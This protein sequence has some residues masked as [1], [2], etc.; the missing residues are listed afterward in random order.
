M[1]NRNADIFRAIALLL[2]VT[3]HSWVLTG[4]NEIFIYPVRL[5]VALGGE[6]GVTSFFILSGFGIYYSLN[7]TDNISFSSF[8]KK[9]FIR[10]AP[11]YYIFLLIL[12]LF[13][14]DVSFISFDGLDDIILHAL[15][16]H[17][18]SPYTA[19]TIN[20]VLWTMSLTVQFYLLAIP[21]YYVIKKHPYLFSIFSILFTILF[22]F[23]CFHYLMKVY[24]VDQY[25]WYSRNLFPSILDNFVLGMFVANRLIDGKKREKN[26]LIGIIGVIFFVISGYL[27]S[28]YS[29]TNG[30]HQDN[31]SGYIY[32][33]LIAICISGVLY[34][35]SDIKINYEAFIIK[36]LLKISD[37]EYGI[38]IVHLFLMQNLLNG[39]ALFINIKNF[40]VLLCMLML[41]VLS[42]IIGTLYSKAVSLIKRYYI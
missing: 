30:I 9:R 18:L 13:S 11:E 19:G 12:L 40:S 42:I 29:W 2:V 3:Y 31:L 34:F 8:M 36:I 15:F 37:F 32:H 39:S 17:N 27:I 14:T 20:G 38:Y 7:K 35:I 10:I 22:K 16:I 28:N 24:Y 5:L 6:I 4:S 33:S 41:I 25:F 23:F 26:N 21:L 1:R